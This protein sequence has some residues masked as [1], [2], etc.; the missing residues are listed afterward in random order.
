[1][2][3]KTELTTDCDIIYIS[4]IYHIENIAGKEGGAKEV[5]DSMQ[6]MRISEHP[7]SIS[8]SLEN[9]I[10][11]DDLE[12]GRLSIYEQIGGPVTVQQLVS[13]FTVIN[14]AALLAEVTINSNWKE[15]GVFIWK[16][17]CE[18]GHENLVESMVKQVLHFAGYYSQFESVA[19]TDREF[20]KW[21]PYAK[22]VF[23]NFQ[24]INRVYEYYLDGHITE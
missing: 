12:H 18:Y 24:K 2:I 17:S 14:N 3:A 6:L 20:E 7:I 1:M 19:I 9:I 21:F 16:I 13:Q 23:S 5:I 4:S 8:D 11:F 15:D 22:S 10:V